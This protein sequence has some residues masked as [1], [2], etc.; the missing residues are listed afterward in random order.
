MSDPSKLAMRLEDAIR[1]AYAEA[2]RPDGDYPDDGEVA[3]IIDEAY[4]PLK[5]E[6]DALRK[7][8]DDARLKA[9]EL[10]EFIRKADGEVNDE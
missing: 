7:H 9:S 2:S 4:K 6:R 1:E 5:A 8:L 3:S 10:Y